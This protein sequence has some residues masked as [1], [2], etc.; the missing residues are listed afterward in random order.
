MAKAPF[1]MCLLAAVATVAVELAL[2]RYRPA[3][4]WSDYAAIA[5]VAGPY[6]LL[7]LIA[8]VGQAGRPGSFVLQLATVI[9]AVGGLTLVAMEWFGY[10]EAIRHSPRGAEYMSTRYQRMAIFFVPLVQWI[11]AVVLGIVLLTVR[12]TSRRE[13]SRGPA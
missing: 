10:Y 4:H 13:T 2:D 3:V 12:I 5:S 8:W 11:G 1:A 7:A 6:F 9:L